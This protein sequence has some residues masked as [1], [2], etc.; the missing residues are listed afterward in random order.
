MTTLLD[1]WGEYDG[2][3]FRALIRGTGTMAVP[4]EDERKAETEWCGLAC[5]PHRSPCATIRYSIAAE[6]IH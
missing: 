3:D 6:T 2:P 5:C 4:F 1:D